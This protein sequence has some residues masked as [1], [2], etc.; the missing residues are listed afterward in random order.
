MTS[1]GIFFVG[2]VDKGSKP[3]YRWDPASSAIGQ[4]AELDGDIFWQTPDFC[5]SPDGKTILYSQQE[6]SI[7]QVRMIEGF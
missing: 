7:S 6:I 1:P 3:V 4:V 2:T 5:V